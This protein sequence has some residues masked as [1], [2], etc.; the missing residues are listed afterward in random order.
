M[1]ARTYVPQLINMLRRVCLY[2]IR[3]R[4]KIKAAGAAGTGDALD[5]LVAACNELL[6]LLPVDLPDE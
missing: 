1:A 5:Q 2:V 3:Y 6:A 4:D